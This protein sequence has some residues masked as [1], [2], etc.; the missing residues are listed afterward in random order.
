DVGGVPSTRHRSPHT[1]AVIVALCWRGI[2]YTPV[3]TFANEGD[4]QN[5][6]TVFKKHSRLVG[7]IGR[8]PLGSPLRNEG[9]H[10]I[11]PV[12]R[13]A[14]REPLRVRTAEAVADD[15]VVDALLFPSSFFSKFDVAN[16][17]RGKG[18]SHLNPL[19]AGTFRARIL[20]LLLD[21]LPSFLRP[22]D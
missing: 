7:E 12:R 8:C 18:W 1:L 6:A 9:I 4:P 21:E 16:S 14:Q 3:Q 10:Q 15:A 19:S 11:V 20:K 13:S 2:E 17:R 22:P 5:R